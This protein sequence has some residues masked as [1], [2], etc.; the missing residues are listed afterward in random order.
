MYVIG[1]VPTA[2][3]LVMQASLSSSHDTAGTDSPKF[4]A[5]NRSPNCYVYTWDTKEM[6]PLEGWYYDWY[7]WLV[8]CVWHDGTTVHYDDAELKYSL[9]T[10]K[11]STPLADEW[12]WMVPCDTGGG[13][14][15]QLSQADPNVEE[16]DSYWQPDATYSDHGYDLTL[17][18]PAG[19]THAGSLNAL[20]KCLPRYTPINGFF[21][22]VTWDWEDPAGTTNS[23]ERWH[24][25][26]WACDVY[27]HKDSGKCPDTEPMGMRISSFDALSP[28]E[29][30]AKRK[31]VK[32]IFKAKTENCGGCGGDKTNGN[33]WHEGWKV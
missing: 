14:C 3:G 16:G 23:L 25:N 18:Y 4:L 19:E 17:V 9:H 10:D 30:E 5:A 1:K 13:S 12:P 2:G 26:W 28:E 32:A 11:T 6:P 29:L 33:K 15:W 20:L 7:G 27:P 22:A 31:V 8:T 24:A 21:W